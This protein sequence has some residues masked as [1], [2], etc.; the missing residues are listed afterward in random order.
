MNDQRRKQFPTTGANGVEPNLGTLVG[1]GLHCHSRPIEGG[2]LGLAMKFPR[3]NAHLQAT[4]L[5][6][7]PGNLAGFSVRKFLRKIASIYRSNDLCRAFSFVYIISKM[8]R[9]EAV[10]S[11]RAALLDWRPAGYDMQFTALSPLGAPGVIGQFRA[12]LSPLEREHT[13]TSRFEPHRQL[14]HM[15]RPFLVI[16]TKALH[17]ICMLCHLHQD[18]AGAV[19]IQARRIMQ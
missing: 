13:G 5:R 16:Q 12:T 11:S 18:S 6:K 4:R 3:R 15:C 14:R 10:N 9:P 2:V 7:A 1:R 17:G 19:A 8:N